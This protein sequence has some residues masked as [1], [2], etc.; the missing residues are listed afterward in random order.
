MARL[1]RLWPLLVVVFLA[2]IVF[3]LFQTG[4]WPFGGSGA[5]AGT[6]NTTHVAT[7][8]TGG[9]TPTTTGGTTGTTVI[10]DAQKYL[11]A[12]NDW[13][14]AYWKKAD[15]TT[16]T[17]KKPGAPTAREI[18]QTKD[19]LASMHT[20]AT[21]LRAINAPKEVAMAHAAFYAALSGEISELD[22]LLRAIQSKNKRDIELSFRYY[23]KARDLGLAAAAVL[24]PYLGEAE[25]TGTTLSSTASAGEMG[26]VTYKDTAI[27]FTVQWPKA[28]Q[29]LPSAEFVDKQ[30]PATVTIAISDLPNGGA[31][32]TNMEVVEIEANRWN[33]KTGASPLKTLQTDWADLK[34]DA[35]ASNQVVTTQAPHQVKV[36]GV[37]A[38][39][40][41]VSFVVKGVPFKCREVYIGLGQ[42]MVCFSVTA[43]DENWDAINKVFDAIVKSLKTGSSVPATG[44]VTG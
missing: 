9:T 43:E 33:A 12:M 28:W 44:G 18:Q 20:A 42:A 5:D 15:S 6:T 11:K 16:L 22:R 31:D 35:D 7:H 34:S 38:A 27:G 32:T 17:F 3:A 23:I 8:A 19:Y 21:A 24:D 36:N 14:A 30:H 37:D 39:E 40:A 25:I 29:T 13:F 41:T 1:K 10:S 4:T 26:V 2:L